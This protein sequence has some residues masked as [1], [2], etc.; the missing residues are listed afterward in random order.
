MMVPKYVTDYIDKIKG[1]TVMVNRERHKLIGFLENNI[2]NRDD[3]Y[4]DTQKIEDYIKFSEKWF[5]N[6]KTSKSL[7]HVLYFCTKKKR[8]HHII[9][10]YSFLWR[11][12]AVKMVTSVHWLHSL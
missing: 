6:Y 3:L 11:V 9:R 2:L 1:G 12:V 10:N 5:S 7:Y 8:Y 4:F